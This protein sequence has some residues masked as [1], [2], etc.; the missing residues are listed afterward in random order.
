M[1]EWEDTDLWKFT[2]EHQNIKVDSWGSYGGENDGY[3]PFGYS[4]TYG[5]KVLTFGLDGRYI[6]TRV[7]VY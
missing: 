2:A 1:K 4:V 3:T 5:N 6:S 7:W